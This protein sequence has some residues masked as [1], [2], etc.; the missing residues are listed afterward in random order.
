MLASCQNFLIK[1]FAHVTAA[2]IIAALSAKNPFLYNA[3]S[4]SL[5]GQLSLIHFIVWLA[6]SIGSLF[7]M[8]SLP[9]NTIVKYMAAVLFAFI[10]G[11]TSGY[12]MKRLEDENMVFHVF[13]LTIGVFVGMIA[14]GLFDNQNTLKFGPY[15][16]GAL[17]GLFI[18][19]IILI[20]VGESNLIDRKARTNI[21]PVIAFIAVGIFSLLSAY[22]TQILK[23]RAAKC[24]GSP[25]YIMESTNLFL[26]FQNLFNNISYLEGSN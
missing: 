1:T 21:E 12:T 25:D 23:A 10:I 16:I 2:A 14:I 17:L 8:L 24:K 13:A 4:K 5:Q 26:T 20:I 7:L 22:E 6:I 9:P 19:E 18:T 15:L 11:Q 3:L